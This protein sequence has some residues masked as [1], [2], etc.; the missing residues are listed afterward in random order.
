MKKVILLG[1]ILVGLL[2][3][4]VDAEGQT[5]KLR[6]EL[7]DRIEVLSGEFGEIPE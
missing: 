7:E 1:W 2:V 3:F 5:R 4:S 6:K